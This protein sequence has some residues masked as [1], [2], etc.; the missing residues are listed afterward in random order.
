M[1]CLFNSLRCIEYSGSLFW[2]SLTV[3]LWDVKF[4]TLPLLVIEIDYTLFR[5]NKIKDWQKIMI[6]TLI[7]LPTSQKARCL[8]C[9]N[10]C[11]TYVFFIIPISNFLCY[12]FHDLKQIPYLIMKITHWLSSICTSEYWIYMKSLFRFTS[13]IYT[14]IYVHVVICVFAARCDLELTL[15]KIFGRTDVTAIVTFIVLYI[16]YRKKNYYFFT[17]PK[18]AFLSYAK[19]LK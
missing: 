2:K 6:R 5:R 10:T 13:S 1:L 11:N 15:G 4:C 9:G 16:W 19:K 18:L 7:I 14:N 17:F 3:K 8:N 12:K